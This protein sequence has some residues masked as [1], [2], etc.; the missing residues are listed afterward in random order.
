M[1]IY[2]PGAGCKGDAKLVKPGDELIFST[3]S[4]WHERETPLLSVVAVKEEASLA[5]TCPGQAQPS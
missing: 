1:Y 4:Q 5:M 2:E 3:S